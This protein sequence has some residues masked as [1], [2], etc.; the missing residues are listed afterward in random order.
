MGLGT[1]FVLM[2]AAMATAA[3]A[4][5]APPVTAATPSMA[6]KPD[7]Q[8]MDLRSAKPLGESPTLRSLAARAAKPGPTAPSEGVQPPDPVRNLNVNPES[9]R[10]KQAAIDTGELGETAMPTPTSWEGISNVQGVYP[11]DTNADVSPNYVVQMVNSS[12]QVFSKG[13]TSLLGPLPA[14]APWA[15]ESGPCKTSL[16]GDVIVKYDDRADRWMVSQLANAH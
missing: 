1:R 14:N 9:G 12:F 3:M 6:V 4:L 13:G 15:S 2:S 5:T 10:P 11:P 8:S 16:D 7:R